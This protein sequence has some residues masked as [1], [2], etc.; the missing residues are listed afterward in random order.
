[1]NRGCAIVAILVAF[2]L[3]APFCWR[4]RLDT[5]ESAVSR[6]ETGCHI[7]TTSNGG[8]KSRSIGPG[9]A[10][11][12]VAYPLDIRVFVTACPSAA[13]GKPYAAQLVSATSGRVVARGLACGKA[14]EPDFPCRLEIPPLASLEGSDR[15]IV[16]VLR[17]PGE[18][19]RRADLRLYV[20]HAW[21]SVL[22]DALGSV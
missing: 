18:P 6:N 1:V 5:I 3:L 12:E 4:Y 15:Y 19:V 13:G 16:R 10:A 14:P 20:S 7:D 2:G 11:E 21:R 8:W 22:L 9:I 17:V